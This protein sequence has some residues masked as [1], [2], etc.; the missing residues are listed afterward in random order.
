M[1]SEGCE[2]VVVSNPERNLIGVRR[3]ARTPTHIISC[4]ML[5]M[6]IKELE[7]AV[8]S[9]FAFGRARAPLSVASSTSQGARRDGEQRS[10]PQDLKPVRCGTRT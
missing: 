2:A 8:R 5:G 1:E 3:S 9:T 4:P 7:P 10:H 6:R